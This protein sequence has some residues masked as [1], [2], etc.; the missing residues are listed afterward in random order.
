MKILESGSPKKKTVK[1]CAFLYILN[2]QRKRDKRDWPTSTLVK[3]DFVPTSARHKVSPRGLRLL[4][5]SWLFEDNPPT[6]IHQAAFEV[7]AQLHVS[8]LCRLHQTH[9]LHVR[10]NLWR[11]NYLAAGKIGSSVIGSCSYFSIITCF[12]IRT[13]GFSGDTSFCPKLV[14]FPGQILSR[15]RKYSQELTSHIPFLC[16]RCPLLSKAIYCIRFHT[17]PT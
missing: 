1:L 3:K 17:R 8:P 10:S 4:I 15:S 16:P 2:V 11:A 14:Y 6:L 13:P 12:P 9:V 5:P 7:P